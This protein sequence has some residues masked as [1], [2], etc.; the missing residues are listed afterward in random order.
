MA[1]HDTDR[2]QQIL[3]AALKRFAEKGYAGTSIQEIVDAARVTK[4]T[5][6]YYFRNKADLYRALVEWAYDQRYRLM[7]EAAGRSR[8]L[9]GQLTEICSVLFEFIRD[10][11]ELTRLAFA[12]AFAAPGEVPAEAGC[13]Q[14]GLHSFE[15]LRDLIGKAA[16]QGELS[17]RFAPEELAMAFVG[18][19]HV[20]IMVFL[21]K[22]R[23]PP[24]RRTA[25]RMVELFLAG[26]SPA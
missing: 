12:T 15:F 3:T 18:M 17:H 26:A 11:R 16:A 6:Y 23:P 7:Q 13:S 5:L 8:H 24:N 10:Q 22:L 21:I 2:R 4:P 20:H 19:M 14:K 1:R 25:R 9:A